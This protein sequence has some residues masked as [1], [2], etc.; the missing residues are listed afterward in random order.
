MPNKPH[1]RNT[2]GAHTK[3][4]HLLPSSG[5]RA[6]PS[7]WTSAPEGCC[8]GRPSSPFSGCGA[9]TNWFSRSRFLSVD[10]RKEAKAL[11]LVVLQRLHKYKILWK[12]GSGLF[13]HHVPR[14]LGAQGRYR[15][16][17]LLH[18]TGPPFFFSPIFYCDVGAHALLPLFKMAH[19]LQAV[20]GALGYKQEKARRKCRKIDKSSRRK[21]CVRQQDAGLFSVTFFFSSQGKVG[22]STTDA[23][24]AKVELD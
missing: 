21:T 5:W 3:G 7:P 13:V 12:K 19:I 24:Y 16:P 6:L 15:C 18:W 2:Y 14:V 11:Q 1:T 4:A 10:E 20:E 22:R 23:C 8:D 9:R 17:K